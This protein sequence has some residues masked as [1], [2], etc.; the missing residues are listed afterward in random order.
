MSDTP[1]TDALSE[2]VGIQGG[3]SPHGYFVSSAFARALERELN[4]ATAEAA[5]LR[6]L[7][8]ARNFVGFTVTAENKVAV[9]AA[10]AGGKGG[11]L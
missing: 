5:K 4:A 8:A 2:H 11:T 6:E 7:L 3:K 1:R 9:D 10:L